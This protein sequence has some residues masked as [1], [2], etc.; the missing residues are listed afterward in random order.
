MILLKLTKQGTLKT[1]VKVQLFITSLN[2]SGGGTF[3]SSDLS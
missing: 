3:I 1:N 2:L